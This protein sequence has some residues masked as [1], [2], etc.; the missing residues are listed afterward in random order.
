MKHHNTL[1]RI[2]TA[3]VDW[4]NKV[5]ASH[6]ERAKLLADADKLALPEKQKIDTEL[7]TYYASVAGVGVK[8]R[9][10]GD[11]MFCN[12]TAAWAR[13]DDKKL[14]PKSQAA[15]MAL[16]RSRGI[17]FAR[18]KGKKAPAKGKATTPAKVKA[19]TLEG[20]VAFAEA[21][22]AA[23]AEGTKVTGDERKAIRKAAQMLLSLI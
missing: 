22:F 23:L 6:V 19:A 14:T 9:E 17:L 7:V 10:K 18:E 1:S 13:D 8:A 11:A 3:I 16:S 15:A 2:A 21:R 20:V 4:S 5:T 12:L